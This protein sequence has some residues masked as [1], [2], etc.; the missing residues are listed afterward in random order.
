MVIQ[1]EETLR[2]EPEPCLIFI[3]QCRSLISGVIYAPL[4][5][6]YAIYYYLTVVESQNNSRKKAS[7][8]LS[9]FTLKKLL[10][11]HHRRHPY[12]ILTP[13]PYS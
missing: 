5:L 12:P 2:V 13:C 9:E 10:I 1:R 11:A 7:Q 4:F 3:P 6:Y 8:S